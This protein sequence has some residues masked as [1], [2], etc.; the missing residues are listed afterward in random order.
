MQDILRGS[1]VV[2]GA[3]QIL[4]AEALATY[5]A[6]CERIRFENASTRDLHD[7]E[8]FTMNEAR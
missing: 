7:A 8:V 3:Q 6:I 2:E 1:A 4:E 5:E